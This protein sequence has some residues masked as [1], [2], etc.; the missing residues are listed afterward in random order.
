MSDLVK[1]SFEQRRVLETYAYK[2]PLWLE[3][4]GSAMSS[5]LRSLDHGFPPP[6]EDL[7][8]LQERGD[9]LVGFPELESAVGVLLQEVSRHRGR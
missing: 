6:V 7:A 1:L 9:K 8:A 2:R 5:L 4:L 3:P